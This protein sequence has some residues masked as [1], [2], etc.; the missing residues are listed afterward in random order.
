MQRSF[1]FW[2]V[3]FDKH[4]MRFASFLG[5]RMTKRN[6]TKI[7]FNN[8]RTKGGEAVDVIVFDTLDNA[9]FMLSE[10]YNVDSDEFTKLIHDARTFLQMMDD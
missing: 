9:V 2:L 4:G 1:G 3:G 7:A 8:M 6:Y 10:K 5:E